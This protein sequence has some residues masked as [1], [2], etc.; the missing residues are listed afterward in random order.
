MSLRAY[1]KFTSNEI[2][3][4]IK[5]DDLFIDQIILLYFI[6]FFA[7]NELQENVESATWLRILWLLVHTFRSNKKEGRVK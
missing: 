4:K 5:M 7:D 2:E 1:R 3:R 6:I